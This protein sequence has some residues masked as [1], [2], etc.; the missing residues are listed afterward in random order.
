VPRPLP[1]GGVCP[2]DA[3]PK[4]PPPPSEEGEISV[5]NR[6]DLIKVFFVPFFSF[7]DGSD[8]RIFWRKKLSRRMC[9]STRLARRCRNTR[10]A[11]ARGWGL[12]SS[13]LRRYAIPREQEGLGNPPRSV[14][15]VGSFFS[16]EGVP[17]PRRAGLVKRLCHNEFQTEF[18]LESFLH[19]NERFIIDCLQE[20]KKLQMVNQFFE[21]LEL[22]Y[23]NGAEQFVR[24]NKLWDF[25]GAWKQRPPEE[26]AVHRLHPENRFHKIAKGGKFEK[27]PVPF[28]ERKPEVSKPEE[29]KKER[30][31][32]PRYVQ[33]GGSRMGASPPKKQE[34]KQPGHQ[35]P[36]MSQPPSSNPQP[37]PYAGQPYQYY[38]DYL[39]AYS[40]GYHPYY[41]PPSAPNMD[42][43]YW[44][45]PKV[46]QSFHPYPP[47]SQYGQHPEFPQYSYSSYPYQDPQSGQANPQMQ[48]P[49]YPYPYPVHY[50]YQPAIQPHPVS[51][52]PQNDR[53]EARHPGAAQ[54]PHP[55]HGRS[56][57]HT[58]PYH[59]SYPSFPDQYQLKD[60]QRPPQRDPNN[61]PRHSDFARNHSMEPSEPSLTSANKHRGAHSPTKHRV[62]QKSQKMSRIDDLFSKLV[63]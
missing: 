53:K 11:T 15:T 13:L 38:P 48:V 42:S 39:A 57:P 59:P 5:L 40:G 50:P 32:A 21:H 6:A 35:P 47:P 28:S 60:F 37:D 19:M 18:Q 22:K 51:P 63:P 27:K 62:P 20:G 3:L 9:P 52:A 7:L 54:S 34:T 1:L 16:W 30:A 8:P 12:P 33:Q 44:Q 36:P 26:D 24:A 4:D 56:I 25:Y 17:I 49:Y 43:S 29:Q 41:P 10:P 61:F 31:P 45:D 2:S 14:C 46:P 55:S 58:P 23:G